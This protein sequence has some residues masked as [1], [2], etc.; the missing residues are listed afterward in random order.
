VPQ[1]P[2]NSTAEAKAIDGL[3]ESYRVWRASRLGRVTDE[4]EER[5]LL[6]LLG[7]VDGLQLLDLGCGDGVLASKLAHRGA[8]VTGLD[9]DARMLSAARGRARQESVELHLVNGRVE[10]PPFAD[11]AFDCVV[12]V[13]VLC[14]IRDAD[15]TIARLV[16]LLRPGGRMIIGELGRWNLWAASRRIHG[17][18]GSPTWSAARFRTSSELRSLLHSHGM[19]ITDVRGAV[20]YPPL[21]LTAGLL[22]RFDPWLGRRTTLGAAFVAVSATRPA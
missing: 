8:F 15:R 21:G 9:A 19:A 14:F 18:F 16:R 12:A 6:D 20:F 2:G 11:G 13:T 4:I 1:A 7:R 3:P 22:A 5:L 17:W 10:A